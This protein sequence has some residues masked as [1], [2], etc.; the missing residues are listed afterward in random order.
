MAEIVITL[1]FLVLIAGW[2]IVKLSLS[3]GY[4]LRVTQDLE[5]ALSLEEK[6]MEI[7]SRPPIN[8]DSLLSRM[9]TEAV[10]K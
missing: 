1:L 9:R 10:D 8:A 2:L 5:G 3:L 7:A 6:R 4:K